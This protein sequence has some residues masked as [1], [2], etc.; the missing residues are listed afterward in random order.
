MRIPPA[1]L[2]DGSRSTPSRSISPEIPSTRRL[3][4]SRP[5]SV[6]RVSRSSLRNKFS[7]NRTATGFS[8]QALSP[9]VNP[10]MARMICLKN[11]TSLISTETNRF[12]WAAKSAFNSASIFSSVSRMA[13]L[14][15]SMAAAFSVSMSL[16]A[17]S[18]I[19]AASALACAT[20][21]A[22]CLWASCNTCSA[23]SWPALTPSSRSRSM[24]SC[25]PEILVVS[26]M[27][28]LLR[29]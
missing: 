11:S 27:I 7:G 26:V 8:P 18:S 13:I 19:S 14:S 17:F 15:D 16:R 6:N 5:S 12:T 28:N 10:A 4:F 24:S 3:K 2:P 21:S 29:R 25:T 23:F 9:T 22:A 1:I 20:I